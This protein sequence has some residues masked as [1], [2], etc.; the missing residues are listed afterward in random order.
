MRVLTSQIKPFREKLITVRA[1]AEI[2][3][4]T[5]LGI[6]VIIKVRKPKLYRNSILDKIIREKRTVYEARLLQI[7]YSGGINVPR[8]YF[9]DKVNSTL[10]EDRI[11]GQQLKERIDDENWTEELIK[12]FGILISKLHGNNIIHGDLTTSNIYVT[13]SDI[14]YLIDFGLGKVSKKIEDK[15]VDLNVLYRALESTHPENWNEI[16]TVFE[17]T[18]KSSNKRAKSILKR[19]KEIEN[20]VRYKSH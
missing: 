4:G 13:T 12:S 1:E 17:K 9:V 7:C 19:F 18:Y 3:N 11:E 14:P 2:Y 5:Y 8:V 15:A 16:W 20:R 6:P 10:V